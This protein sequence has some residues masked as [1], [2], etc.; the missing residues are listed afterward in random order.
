MTDASPSQRRSLSPQ[1]GAA[2]FIA[3]GMFAA[4][5]GAWYFQYG[6][7][8]VPCPLCYQQRIPYYFAI[9][10][11]LG[12]AALAYAGGAP[13]LVRLALALLTLVLL[14]S[15]GL[16][17][18]HAG[19]EWKFWQGPAGCAAAPPTVQNFDNLLDSIR[20]IRAVPCDEAAWRFFGISLAGYNALISTALALVALGAARAK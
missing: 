13:R 1:G 16:G 14:V 4:L 5:A 17:V 9:P 18:Y 10:L 19:V 15:A 11:G 2:L 8:Y 12:I 7:G 20:N 6:L 3:A